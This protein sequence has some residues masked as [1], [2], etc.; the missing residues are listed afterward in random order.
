M[1]SYLSDIAN[2]V[3]SGFGKSSYLLAFE[4][5]IIACKKPIAKRK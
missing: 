5:A 4:A 3:I 1:H 2:G